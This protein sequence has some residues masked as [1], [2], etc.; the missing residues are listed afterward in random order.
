MWVFREWWW[1]WRWVLLKAST[2]SAVYIYLYIYVCIYTYT[3]K[4]T[5]LTGYAAVPSLSVDAGLRGGAV[6]GAGSVQVGLPGVV[7][8][9]LG[10]GRVGGPGTAVSVRVVCLECSR[11]AT[12]HSFVTAVLKGCVRGLRPP[13]Y[14]PHVRA[15][16]G[17]R[18][19]THTRT[20][21]RTHARTHAHTKLPPPHTHT[22]TPTHT[23]CCDHG[24]CD[25]SLAR[26]TSATIITGWHQLSYCQQ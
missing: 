23:H 16:I 6:R 3:S 11:P 17:R 10:H 25:P 5:A 19:G 22:D 2:C 13:S 9:L 14:L 26:S 1:K 8:Q 20:H 4:H 15:E 7:R 18:A 21:T 12:G 24:S